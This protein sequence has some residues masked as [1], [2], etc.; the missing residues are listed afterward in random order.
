MG[1]CPICKRNIQEN[2]NG[3]CK[4]SCGYTEV[5][6]DNKSKE[7]RVPLT[8]EEIDQIVISLRMVN[9]AFKGS[10]RDDLEEKMSNYSMKAKIIN[11]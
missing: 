11:S 3:V 8:W 5:T 4:C 1:K 2:K 6:A 10:I 7:I 9:K